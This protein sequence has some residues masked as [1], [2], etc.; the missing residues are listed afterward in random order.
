MLG[1]PDLPPQATRFQISTVD[2]FKVGKQSH[3]QQVEKPGSRSGLQVFFV[4]GSILTIRVAK[5]QEEL[6][7]IILQQDLVA[8]DLHDAAIERE[9]DH[10][11]SLPHKKGRLYLLLLPVCPRHCFKTI[12]PAITETRDEE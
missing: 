2:A 9:L 5:V 8:S 6:S 11:F 7:F 10:V 4:V 12:V 3:Y 1:L